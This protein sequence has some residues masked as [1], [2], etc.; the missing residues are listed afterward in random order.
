MDTAGRYVPIVFGLIAGTVILDNTSKAATTNLSMLSNCDDTDND[1]LLVE[2]TTQVDSC[3]RMLLTL[4]SSDYVY[5]GNNSLLHNN[6]TIQIICFDEQGHPLICPPYNTIP[7]DYTDLLLFCNLTKVSC[8]L[9][10]VGNTV[11]IV[12][13]LLFKVARSPVYLLVVNLCIAKHCLRST[14]GC[15]RSN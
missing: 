15:G 7:P 11:V 6:Q 14:G 4:N 9:S 2:N 5:L 1:S 13:F 12:T 10:I 3:P 8:S